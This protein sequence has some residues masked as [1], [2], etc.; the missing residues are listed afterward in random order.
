MPI[1]DRGVAPAGVE[2]ITDWPPN[3]EQAR[4]KFPI[5]PDVI[6]TYAPAIY[7]PSGNALSKALMA[8]ELVHIRQQ[9]ADPEGWWARYLEDPEFRLEM[10]LPAHKMEFRT[11]CRVYRDRNKQAH[12]RNQIARRL[13]GPLYGGLISYTK[14]KKELT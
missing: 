8:H 12:A 1:N 7:V 4:E 14:A 2:V 6:F 9:G 5:T 13:S 11:F 3:I 10:E